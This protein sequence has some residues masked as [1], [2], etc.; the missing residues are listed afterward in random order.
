MKNLKR[1][2]SLLVVISSSFVFATNAQAATEVCTVSDEDTLAT[3]LTTEGTTTLKVTN[4]VE[5]TKDTTI[6]G[7]LITI[8]A[9]KKLTVKEDITLDY[10]G[11][12]TADV[13]NITLSGTGSE[14]VVN[15][16]LNAK[17]VASNIAI[18]ASATTGKITIGQK[19]KLSISNFKRGGIAALSE[20]VVNGNLTMTGNG[21]GSNTA[22]ITVNGTGKVVANQNKVG[23]TSELITEDGAVVE[24][25]NNEVIGI[26]LKGGT[27]IK[28]GSSVT[29]TGNGDGSDTQ[30]EG[31]I[32]IQATSDNAAKIEEGSNVKAG[33]IRSY[34]DKWP[35]SGNEV[36]YVDAVLQVEG[37]LD[38]ESVNAESLSV[39]NTEGN[40][41][42]VNANVEINSPEFDITDNTLVPAEGYKYILTY[43]GAKITN[44]TDKDISIY[45]RDS[46]TPFVVKAN[47][48]EAEEYY[49]V[50]V[51]V[52]GDLYILGM[53]QT[54]NDLIGLEKYKV[55]EGYEFVKFV[56]V[57][58]ETREVK[59]DE[60]ILAEVGIMPLFAQ[61]SSPQTGDNAIA[62]LVIGVAGLFSIALA[63]SALVVKNR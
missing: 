45:P 1:I 37:N 26:N 24:A 3:C 4:D 6:D 10:T 56:L 5:I 19:G 25:N 57:S 41:A 40:A 9:G 61:V 30:R 42:P 7:L 21:Y 27:D 58:D 51:Y 14:L 38:V 55:K 47:T 32:T 35:E 49:L 53:G 29:A 34:Y 54:L 11:V 48:T 8:D 59:E 31:D 52:D 22:K 63:S 60:F 17:G 13:T 50:N 2:A 43:N 44:S 39:K 62:Y 36:G 23:F 20:I 12:E 15:G 33:T 18:Q 28:S 46:K 16:T